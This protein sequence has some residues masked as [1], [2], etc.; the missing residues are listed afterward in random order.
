VLNKKRKIALYI[1]AVIVYLSSYIILSM[2]GEY[3]ITMSG[4]HRYS[5][6]LAMMDIYKW[7]PYG[8]A[9][10]IYRDV[11]GNKRIHRLNFLGALYS[12]LVWIDRKYIH[13]NIDIFT[14]TEQQK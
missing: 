13:K 12:P 14:M 1:L 3:Q 11:S 7:I 4:E 10:E 6:G 2:C 8:V 5:F 9:C